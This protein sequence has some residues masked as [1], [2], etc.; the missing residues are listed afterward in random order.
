METCCRIQVLNAGMS[1]STLI[2]LKRI[3][4]PIENAQSTEAISRISN[5]HRQNDYFH[6]IK[7]RKTLL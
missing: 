7:K 4:D 5:T 6:A 3:S 2:Y 1:V